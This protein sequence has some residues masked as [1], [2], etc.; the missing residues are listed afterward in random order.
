MYLG[1]ELTSPNLPKGITLSIC[2]ATVL[3]LFATQ[4]A[5]FSPADIAPNES[6]IFIDASAYSGAKKGTTVK[7]A[8]K[9]GTPL[10][11]SFASSPTYGKAYIPN[12]NDLEW[13]I[14]GTAFQEPWLCR[15]TCRLACFT[16]VL[17][18]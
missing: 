10:S 6:S 3:I 14:A 5:A 4:G 12:I 11:T 1:E 2:W 18:M 16:L 7:P 8:D 9:Q 15:R 17:D 13:L